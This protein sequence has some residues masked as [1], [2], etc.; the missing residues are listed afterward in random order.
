MN[1]VALTSF[2]F[3]LLILI[4]P[5][6]V[7]SQ[8]SQ[9]EL[10][11]QKR[12]NEVESARTS[13][14]GSSSPEKKPITISYIEGVVNS[15]ANSTLLLDSK[16]GPKAIYTNEST[17]FVNI[18]ASGKK[19]IGFGDLKEGETIMVIGLSGESGKGSAKIIVRDQRTRQRYFSLLGR[20]AELSAANF[21][22]KDYK[23]DDMPKQ[24]LI[25]GESLKVKKGKETVSKT[26]LKENSKVVA[27]GIVD[28]KGSLT[29][30]EIL[31][32]N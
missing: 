16:N 5:L 7:F 26:E 22:V 6:S 9:E 32:L 14:S 8:S 19:L 30:T 28:E 27:V 13:S 11:T 4:S 15:G 29:A 10:E 21:S 12:L 3:L 18:D 17:K 24:K 2:L 31:L 20:A 25:F 23:R 1:K